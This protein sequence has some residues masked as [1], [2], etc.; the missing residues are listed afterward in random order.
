MAVL[1]SKVQL[2]A[3]NGSCEEFL[4]GGIPDSEGDLEDWTAYQNFIEDNPDA[5]NM[6]VTVE[7]Y[8]YGAGET[9]RADE[10]EIA[11]FTMQG[12]D[13]LSH[14]AVQKT[15]DSEFVILLDQEEHIEI[16]MEAMT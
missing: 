6:T 10:Y 2:H 15:Q 12:E 7:S 4:C 13:F 11:L 9:Y 8:V 16:E 14:P 5:S 1:F 3:D